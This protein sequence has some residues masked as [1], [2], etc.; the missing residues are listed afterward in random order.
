MSEK[1]EEKNICTFFNTFFTSNI[2]KYL[3]VHFLIELC[4]LGKNMKGRNC[5]ALSVLFSVAFIVTIFSTCCDAQYLDEIEENEIEQL[6][7][8]VLVQHH[9]HEKVLY[10]DL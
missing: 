7:S 10:L 5:F 8:E 3:F 2:N 6:L 9:L 4:C 1:A